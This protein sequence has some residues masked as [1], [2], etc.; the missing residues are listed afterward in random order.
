MKFSGRTRKMSWDTLSKIQLG[1]HMH[2]ASSQGNPSN[3]EGS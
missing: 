2:T 3:L 1:Q